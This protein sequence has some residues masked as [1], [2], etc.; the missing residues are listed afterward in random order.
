MGNLPLQDGE[1]AQH[2]LMGALLGPD[3]PFQ[4]LEP[5]PGQRGEDDQGQQTE[6]TQTA[7]I[8]HPA[9]SEVRAPELIT[10]REALLRGFPQCRDAPWGVSG[11][12]ISAVLSRR[13]PEAM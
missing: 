1:P 4:L 10:R 3:P 11:A 6:G 9:R 13:L 2:I 8:T 7:E 5:A 12:A